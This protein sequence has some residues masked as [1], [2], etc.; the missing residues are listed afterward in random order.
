M[1]QVRSAASVK[2]ALTSGDQKSEEDFSGQTRERRGIQSRSKRDGDS[3]Y[4]PGDDKGEKADSV[5]KRMNGRSGTVKR[6]IAV[7]DFTMLLH[8]GISLQSTNFRADLQS[9]TR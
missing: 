3:N 6:I 9:K 1:R 7:V 8:P 2:A 4:I 5:D